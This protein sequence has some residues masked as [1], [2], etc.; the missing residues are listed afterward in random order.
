MA[1]SKAAVRLRKAAVSLRMSQ[2]QGAKL[3]SPSTTQP[4]WPPER[5]NQ[6]RRPACGVGGGVQ[7]EVVVVV[8]PD[9]SAAVGDTHSGSMMAC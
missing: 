8:H 7:H 2:L 9:E 3:P 4:P 1:M 5:R 6:H